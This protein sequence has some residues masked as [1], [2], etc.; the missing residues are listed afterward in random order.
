MVSIHISRLRDRL[1]CPKPLTSWIAAHP[2]P[3]LPFRNRHH[4]NT[5]LSTY[6]HFISTPWRGWELKMLKH[7][8]NDDQHFQDTFRDY[9]YEWAQCKK[10][11]LSKCSCK[12]PTEIA[13]QATS[14]SKKPKISI[15]VFLPLSHLQKFSLWTQRKWAQI[16]EQLW[17]KYAHR[18][19]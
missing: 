13:L 16:W 15:F 8:H 7:C 19:L 1:G 11:C 9:P 17:I 5:Q 14:C 18:L 3:N 4:H 12:S 10:G 6:L 2:C